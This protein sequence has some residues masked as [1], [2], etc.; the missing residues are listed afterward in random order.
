MPTRGERNNNPLNMDFIRNDPYLGQIDIE[1]IPPG[2]RETARFGVYDTPEHGIR[3]GAEQ[4]LHDWNAGARTIARLATR[5][6]PVEDDNN[7]TSYANTVANRVG[8]DKSQEINLFDETILIMVVV[9]FIFEEQ[10]RCIYASDVVAAA[11]AS[12]LQA[13]SP[14]AAKP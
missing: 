11:C 13:T 4:L 7:P 5:W 2:I 3:A 1:K 6:A 8:V 14:A 10:G 12:A 9:A